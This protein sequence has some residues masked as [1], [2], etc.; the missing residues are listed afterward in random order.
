MT[1]IPNNSVRAIMRRIVLWVIPDEIMLIV[2]YKS[3]VTYQNQVGGVMCAQ[4]AL[5]GVLAPIDFGDE[6]TRQIQGCS[7]PP[8]KQGIS[9]E[10]ADMID[11]ILA[12][13]A[14]ARFLRVD[15]GRL[16]ECWEAWIHVLGVCPDVDD[17]RQ[18]PKYFGPIFGFGDVRGV[19]TWPNSD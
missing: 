13:T 19:L 17:L 9:E 15:R 12:N 18:D 6:A 2:A 11:Q 10:V 4:L 8:G 7:F 16:H 1:D 14:G 3:G 5:E